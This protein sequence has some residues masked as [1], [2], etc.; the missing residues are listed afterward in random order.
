MTPWW[1][2]F[3]QK[4]EYL[5][6]NAIHAL[7]ELTE[8]F[9]QVSDIIRVDTVLNFNHIEAEADEINI[10]PILSE[11]DAKDPSKDALKKGERAGASKLDAW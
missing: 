9:Y 2:E 5:P 1:W 6:T 7:R 11:E 4:K 10:G 3:T 8:D